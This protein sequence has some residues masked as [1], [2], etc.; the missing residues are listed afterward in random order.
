MFATDG[1]ARIF[2]LLPWTSCASF[3]HVRVLLNFYHLTPKQR[4]NGWNRTQVLSLRYRSWFL[5]S[6]VLSQHT[7]R[8]QQI[9]Q[10]CFVMLLGWANTQQ[11]K[12]WINLMQVQV[13]PPLENSFYRLEL[14]MPQ[15]IITLYNSN[16]ML[17]G[18]RKAI[19]KTLCSCA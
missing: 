2:P 8:W 6:K 13:L 18:P 5:G 15:L 16:S 12:C 11:K 3:R 10:S 19:Q 14:G 4:K 9:S 17:P 1:V 7:V